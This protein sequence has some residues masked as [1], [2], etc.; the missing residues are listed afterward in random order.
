MTTGSKKFSSTGTVAISITSLTNWLL[1]VGLIKMATF[2]IDILAFDIYE[3]FIEIYQC[4][5]IHFPI[6]IA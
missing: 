5:Y 4:R 6:Q 2:Y 1:I 3:F